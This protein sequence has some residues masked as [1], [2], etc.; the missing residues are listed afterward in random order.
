MWT[1]AIEE[2]FYLVFPILLLGLMTM[3]HGRRRR[4]A[5]GLVVLIVLSAIV[6]AWIYA[7]Q[8]KPMPT[9]DP[10]RIYYGT[11]TRA[12]EL[13]LGA[14]LAV[15][16]TYWRK[17]TL[18]A[19]A[20]KLTW[21]GIASFGGMLAFFFGPNETSAWVFLG[22][23][24]LFS[25]LICL[26]I[27]AVEVWP[28]SVFAEFLSW[29]PIVWIGELSYGIY[30]WHWPIFVFLNEER[31]GW[32]ELV[33][34]VVR[35]TLTVGLATIS[36]YF[37]EQP[38]R[39]QKLQK[40]LGH[41]KSIAAWSLALPVTVAVVVLATLGI[42]PV[43]DAKSGSQLDTTTGSG[44]KKIAVVGD[45][46]G[47][48]LA[49]QFPAGSYP[50]V[51]VTGSAKIGCGTAEQWL[52]VN[53]V[54]QSQDNP[55]CRDVFS[56]WENAVKSSNAKVVVWSMGGWD[57]YDHYVDGKVL[58]E[59]SPEYAR[60]YRS[61]LEKGLAAFGPKTQVFIPKVAC[62]DQPKFEVEGQDLALD[63]NDPARAKALNAIIDDFA[64]AHSD[65]V[66]AVDP[67]SWL[68]KDGKPIEKI[69]GKVM[70][71]DG[72]HYTSDGA[73]KFWAW[74]MPQLKSHL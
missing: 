74:L 43:T 59:Q 12:N 73:K 28:G 7:S 8:I 31:T 46:V 24:V 60:Y 14:A 21:I 64:K 16:M 35:L 66:H 17:R 22:G 1:L 47:Y 30:L 34:L 39:T 33:L 52:V 4:I 38:I 71:E 42:K 13:L 9:P 25:I 3:A 23:S 6:Q 19:N 69:D 40:R 37:I 53:G 44:D 10:S 70:R 68:C 32:N 55:E 62:Y 27:V 15:A 57:V 61:R 5:Q 18:R 58:K 45:S 11:D 56:G 26:I 65:R 41:T 67:S 29:K 63:R 72:V 48:G 49:F 50:G 54:R 51:S 20:E 36:Y 2:Q